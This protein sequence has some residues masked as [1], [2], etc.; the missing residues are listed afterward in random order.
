MYFSDLKSWSV[1]GRYRGGSRGGCQGV[2]FIGAPHIREA[3]HAD[4]DPWVQSKARAAG[5]A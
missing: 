4:K 3:G 1:W 5:G 2:P